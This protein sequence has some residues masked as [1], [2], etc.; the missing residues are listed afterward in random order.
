MGTSFLRFTGKS[1]EAAS[2]LHLETLG[3]A[4]ALSSRCAWPMRVDRSCDRDARNELGFG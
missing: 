4:D 2:V 3:N 1:A